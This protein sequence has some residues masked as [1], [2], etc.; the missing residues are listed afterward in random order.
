MH[1][2]EKRVFIIAKYR[3]PH[4][5]SQA[6]PLVLHIINEPAAHSLMNWTMRLRG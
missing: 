3:Q 2:A 5:A 4:E 6:F 1:T